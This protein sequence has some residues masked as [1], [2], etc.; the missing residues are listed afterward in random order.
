MD[1]DKKYLASDKLIHK[2]IS[3]LL[4]PKYTGIVFYVH[5]FGKF[6]AI[7]IL[8]ALLNFNLTEEG[9]ENPYIISNL[10]TREND[11][12]KLVIKRKIKNKQGKYVT[13]SCNI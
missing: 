11:I 8:K 3:E 4:R 5:N 1:S 12:L 2:C 6:D 10:L 9:K 13:R 7:F